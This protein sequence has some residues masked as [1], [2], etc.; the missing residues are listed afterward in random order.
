[1]KIAV[2]GSRSI[3]DPL[4]VFPAIDRFVK[5]YCSWTPP[6]IISGGAKGVDALAKKWAEVQGFDY[7]EFLPYHK[8]DSRAEYSPTYFFARNLQIVENSDKVLVIWDGQSRGTSHAIEC[9]KSRGV[10]VMVIIPP[11]LDTRE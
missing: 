9:A 6:T 8:I 3:D 5:E 10:P 11:N 4:V 1:M 7:V 2:I